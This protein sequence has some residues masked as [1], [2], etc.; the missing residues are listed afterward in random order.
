MSAGELL[1]PESGQDCDVLVVDDEPIVREACRR[2]LESEGLRVALAQDAR[3]A[4]AHPAARTCRVLLCDLMLPDRPGIE[5]ASTLKALRPGL[6]VVLT[7]GLITPE[8]LAGTA[9]TA[10]RGLLLKPFDESELLEAIRNAL[11]AHAA[12]HA[13]SR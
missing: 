11:E 13:G 8:N 5:I 9:D 12:A 4:L 1:G 7:T 10:Y 6:Q 2:V 3:S